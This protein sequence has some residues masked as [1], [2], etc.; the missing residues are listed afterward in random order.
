MTTPGFADY[1]IHTAFNPVYALNGRLLAVDLLS[2]FTHTSLNVVVPQDILL[3]QFDSEQ[4]LQTLQKQIGIIEHYHDFFLQ[5]N[6]AVILNVDEE[7]AETILSSEFLLRKLRP[8]Q[9]LE[10]AIGES[11]PNFR[12]GKE[13]PLLSALSDNFNLTLNNFG[14]GKAP[15]KAVY[16]NLF[17][18]IRLDKHF[19]QQTLKRV[20]YAS[21]LKAIVHQLSD[22]CQQFIVTGVDDPATLNHIAPFG[23]AGMQ[24][25]LFPPVPENELATLTEPPHGFSDGQC[26]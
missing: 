18:R 3:S 8:F 12:A 4:R 9:A 17:A 10:L 25:A 2:S 13:D 20:T 19:L 23:F 1:F 7:M 24:G 22:H 21:M 5:N 16:D 26:R 15:A 14:S 11:F 6:V